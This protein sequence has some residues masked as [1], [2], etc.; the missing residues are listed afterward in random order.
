MVPI[1]KRYDGVRSEWPPCCLRIHPEVTS[2]VVL[3]TYKLEEKSGER[4][5]SLELY[6]YGPGFLLIRSY[7]A[8]SA[9]L[10]L[11]Y[12]PNDSSMLISAHSTGCV[13]IWKVDASERLLQQVKT[14][15][16]FEESSLVTSIFFNPNDTN[17]L[18][19][20]LTTGE[21]AIVNLQDMSV[22]YLCTSHDLECWTGSFGELGP[23]QNVVFTGG[24]DS[25]LI[26]HD[27]RM[28]SKIWA[29][30]YN[31]HDAGV[32]SILNSGPKWNVANPH[33]M[34]TGSYDDNLRI[35]DLRV[36]DKHN[37]ELITGYIPKVNQKENLGGGVWRLIPSPN[38]NRVLVCCMYDGARI[39][40]AEEDKFVVSKYFKGDHESM[41]YGGDWKKDEVVV[42]CSFYDNVVQAWSPNEDETTDKEQKSKFL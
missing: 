7:P 36:A 20:T 12:N 4:H 18:L 21:L 3:G 40:E 16:L 37:P 42:T 2:L 32:V 24:D 19:C 31:H 29:T 1:S 9:V 11:K 15:Q 34:W 39:V 5:G 14:C 8:C 33:H 23:L 30:S 10:D 26:A 17:Q 27:L 28:Q 35:L 41:C 6:N 38:N 13:V 25:K 22:E